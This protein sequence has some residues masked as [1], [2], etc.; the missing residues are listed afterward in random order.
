[1]DTLAA[2][3]Y[4][5]GKKKKALTTAENAISLAKS[6]GEDYSETQRLLEEINKL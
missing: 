5:L 1:M 6:T 4:K 3:Y 2:L